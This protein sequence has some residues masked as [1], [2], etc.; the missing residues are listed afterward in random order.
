MWHLGMDVGGTK[1]E[2]QVIDHLGE[3]HYQKRVETEKESVSQFIEQVKCLTNDAQSTVGK[4]CSLGIGLPGSPDRETGLI[5]NSNILIL[6]NQPLREL[7]E[8][9]LRQPVALNNDANCFTLSEAIDGAGKGYACVAGVV[10]GTGCGGGLVLNQKIHSGKNGNGGEWGHIPLS[11]YRPEVDGE[12]HHCYC[13]Q[14][15]CTESFISGSGLNRQLRHL[16]NPPLDSVSFFKKLQL[17]KHHDSQMALALF[18]DQLARSLAMLVNMIDP[19]IIVLG[20]G[21][22]NVLP[23]YNGI[24]KEINQY[25]FGNSS[26]ICVVPARHGD[27]SGVRGAAWL[28][29]HPI[30][31]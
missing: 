12:S 25:T 27:S 1:I 26:N 13:G 28:G 24:S 16:I 15:N 17:S 21:L 2:V 31:F 9:N 30:S 19:D 23:L 22:S 7:L 4:K 5:K 18:R 10:L 8:N 6:N 20:G 29:A 3:V 11:G 14:W